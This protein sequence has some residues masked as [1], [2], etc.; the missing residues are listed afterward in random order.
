MGV[1]TELGDMSGFFKGTL[2]NLYK[3]IKIAEVSL[4]YCA[5]LLLLFFSATHSDFFLS[6]SCT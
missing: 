2:Q 6:K 3:Y 5:L 1:Y 4:L